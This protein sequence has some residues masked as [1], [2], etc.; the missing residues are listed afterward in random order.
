MGVQSHANFG[1]LDRQFQ[2]KHQ[3]MICVD[4]L[5]PLMGS[6]E[7]ADIVKWVERTPMWRVSTIEDFLRLSGEGR[8]PSDQP[9]PRNL[10][11]LAFCLEKTPC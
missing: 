10:D 5:V 9:I 11:R 6:T 4:S 2:G 3:G 8:G 7:L 1:I